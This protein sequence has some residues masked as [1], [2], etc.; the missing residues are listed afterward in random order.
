M[1]TD[2]DD[3]ISVLNDLI[4]TCE[5]G[6][7]GFHTAA[8]AVEDPQARSVFNTRADY[9]A[10]S[11]A[12][13][14]ALVRRL[15]GDPEHHGSVSGAVHR[16]W[17]NLKAAVTG[18]DD[19]AIIAECERGEDAAVERYEDALEQDLPP[20]VRSL[21]DRQYRGT[22]QNRERVRQLRAMVRTSPASRTRGPA[23]YGRGTLSASTNLV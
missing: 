15:G 2:N 22:L 21:V 6:V 18:K 4:E 13:L 20:D 12:D 17:I 9:I 7:R 19:E 5:D 8:D 11:E 3:V 1:A 14:R 10:R 23:A 16:G